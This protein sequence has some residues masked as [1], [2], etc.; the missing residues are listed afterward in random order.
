[1]VSKTFERYIIIALPYHLLFIIPIF[2]KKQKYVLDKGTKVRKR[3]EI[4]QCKNLYL[5]SSLQKFLRL[6]VEHILVYSFLLLL[7]HF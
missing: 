7:K 2:N 1:M 5:W 6:Q 4:G 3:T